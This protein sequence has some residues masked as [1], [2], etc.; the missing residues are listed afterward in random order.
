MTL[1]SLRFQALDGLGVEA[2]HEDRA[3]P[4]LLHTRAL[5]SG[6]HSGRRK[7]GCVSTTHS[8]EVSAAADITALREKYPP[9]GE[10]ASAAPQPAHEAAD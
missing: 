9:G 5:K 4:V 8:N 2:P 6:N 1:N 10:D 3:Y 7:H